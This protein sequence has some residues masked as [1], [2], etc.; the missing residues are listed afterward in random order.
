MSKTKKAEKIVA[1]D[2]DTMLDNIQVEQVDHYHAEVNAEEN[3]DLSGLIG[4][5]M[6]SDER[7]SVIAYFATETEACFYRLALINAR[8]ND[9]K[10]TCEDE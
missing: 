2:L 6:V 1:D 9:I 5:Y 7:R 3:K 10:R 8:L 4:W